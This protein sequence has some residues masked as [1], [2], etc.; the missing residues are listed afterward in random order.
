MLPTQLVNHADLWT[1]IKT[2]KGKTGTVGVGAGGSNR[3]V[4]HGHTAVNLYNTG[5]SATNFNLH[6]LGFKV[7]DAY[8]ACYGSNPSA[9]AGDKKTNL[10]FQHFGDGYNFLVHGNADC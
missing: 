10:A 7:E 8:R 2:L 5:K 9:G 1:S 3:I 4:C 6:E